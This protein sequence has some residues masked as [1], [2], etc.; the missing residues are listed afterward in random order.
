MSFQKFAGFSPI[1]LLFIGFA[2]FCISAANAAPAPLK[3]L[4]FDDMSC[5]AWTQGDADQ[6]ALHL[7]WMRGLLSGH[8]YARPA[9]QVSTISNGTIEQYVIR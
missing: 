5:R 2:A 6:R 1:A 3:V 9:Q 7:A 8:N 4:G